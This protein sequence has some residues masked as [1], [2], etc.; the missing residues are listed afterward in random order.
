MRLETFSMNRV[1]WKMKIV[2]GILLCIINRMVGIPTE[3]SKTYFQ[4]VR[5]L[6]SDFV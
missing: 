6:G 2:C 5:F 1:C 4:Y 3:F